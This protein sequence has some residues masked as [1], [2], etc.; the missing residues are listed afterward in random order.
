[1]KKT[2]NVFCCCLL[3]FVAK[4]APSLLRQPFYTDSL[5]STSYHQSVSH[6]R[7]VTQIKKD[8]NFLGNSITD[9]VEWKETIYD[10]EYDLP[11]LL[12]YPKK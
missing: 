8:K 11:A 6:F 3:L 9:V 10:K 5:F 1:M 7:A 4:G 12:P 2:L